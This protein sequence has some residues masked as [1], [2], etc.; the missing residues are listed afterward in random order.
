MGVYMRIRIKVWIIP[1]FILMLLFSGLIVHLI[2]Q[3]EKQKTINLE[4]DVH[5]YLH[6]RNIP[7]VVKYVRLVNAL[8][9]VAED[10]MTAFEI[11]EVAKIITIHC[12]V[13]SGLGLTPELILAVMER[14]SSFNPRAVSKARAY[15]LMQVIRSTVELHL[16]QL[17]Y[18]TTFSKDLV[19]NPIINV[20]IGIAELV[21]LR[22]LFLS[23][24]VDSWLI[25]L[26]AYFWGERNAWELLNS[27]KRA[28]LPSLEY[29]QG[30]LN[31]ADKWKELNS[32]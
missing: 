22:R 1:A 19:L 4:Q 7:Y 12:E 29:G 13:Y 11:V 2:V 23:E 24:G 26:T 27:R 25:V 6:D 18:G 3:I 14:E 28:S 21:R 31:L 10:K 32:E 16:A 15:G 5:L 8:C 30:V 17:G 9:G 20:E